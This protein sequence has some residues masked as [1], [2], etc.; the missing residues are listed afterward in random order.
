MY[1]PIRSASPSSPK[2]SKITDPE[3]PV[4]GLFANVLIKL[5]F[6]AVYLVLSVVV[7]NLYFMNY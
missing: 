6:N 3:E 2:P 7:F 4:A 1:I 5:R